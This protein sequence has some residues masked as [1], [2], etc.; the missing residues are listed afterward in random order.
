MRKT[1]VYYQWVLNFHQVIL[2][3]WISRASNIMFHAHADITTLLVTFP[4]HLIDVLEDPHSL[5]QIKRENSTN[6]TQKIQQ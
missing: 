4:F 1:Y 5:N 2:C 3:M 6:F